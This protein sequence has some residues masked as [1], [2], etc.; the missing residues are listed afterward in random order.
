MPDRSSC[1]IRTSREALLPASTG[2]R[3]VGEIW[4]SYVLVI[5]LGDIYFKI[6]KIKQN[7]YTP[8]LSLVKTFSDFIV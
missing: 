8:P 6:I 1:V 4:N 2:G 7:Q 5:G 3:V